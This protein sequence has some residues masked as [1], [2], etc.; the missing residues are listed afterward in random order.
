M[1]W[2]SNWL[3][4][5]IYASFIFYLSS[6]SSLEGIPSYPYIDK[7]LHL[8]EYSVLGFLFGRAIYN[9]G[10]KSKAR[11]IIFSILFTTLYGMSDEIHQYF[12][13]LRDSDIMDIAADLIGGAVGSLF[14]SLWMRL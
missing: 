13:P 14:Y 1:K 2:V 3:P 5:I 7:L 8:A 12:V 6:L 4:V 9:Y 10:C 11:L